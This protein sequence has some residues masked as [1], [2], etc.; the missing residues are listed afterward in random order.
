MGVKERDLREP[1]FFYKLQCVMV[2]AWK[3]GL[4]DRIGRFSSPMSGEARSVTAYKL[5]TASSSGS[6]RMRCS[7][8]AFLHL[9]Q[10]PRPVWS[11]RSVLLQLEGFEPPVPQDLLQPE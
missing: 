8:V 9:L 2:L 3:G 6:A 5:A 11:V 1:L 4:Q 7:G 10:G